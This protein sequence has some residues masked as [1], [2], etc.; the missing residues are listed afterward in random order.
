MPEE[1]IAFASG[2]R[3]T[4]RGPDFDLHCPTFG[5]TGFVPYLIA[6]L[7]DKTSLCPGCHEEIGRRREDDHA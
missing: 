5:N 6:L 4:Y 2:H 3:L 1:D 7:L